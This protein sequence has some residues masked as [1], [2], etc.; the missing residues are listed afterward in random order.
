MV[1]RVEG[2]KINNFPERGA[3]WFNIDSCPFTSWGE[4]GGEVV[5]F[6]ILLCV[7]SLTCSSETEALKMFL[8]KFA[9]RIIPEYMSQRDF[10]TCVA[11]DAFLAQVTAD[12]K[13]LNT[14]LGGRNTSGKTV[15]YCLG[16]NKSRVGKFEYR[17]PDRTR[18]EGL[19]LTDARG[20]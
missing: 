11:N 16:I 4:G 17:R 9:G 8:E 7:T 6:W 13:T 3:G 10:L 5:H 12:S 19:I 14:E 15:S 1:K 18:R 20:T 2:R